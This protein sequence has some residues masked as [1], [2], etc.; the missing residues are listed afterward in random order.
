MP[1]CRLDGSEE[2]N[3][4]GEEGI[5]QLR[6]ILRDRG[7]HATGAR[8]AVLQILREGHRHASMDDIREQVLAR[9]P[10]VDPATVYRTLETLETHGLA[11]RVELRDRLTRW[12]HVTTEHHHLLCKICGNVIEIDDAP[13]QRLAQELREQYGVHADMQHLVLHGVCSDC[14]ASTS[15]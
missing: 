2:R 7:L 8:V 1:S 10:T 3:V 13:F 9:Y 4:H 11:V 14:A 15:R 6:T 5:E 12:A